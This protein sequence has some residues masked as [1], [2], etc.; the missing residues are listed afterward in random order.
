[1][2][3]YIGNCRICG[4]N[5]YCRDGFAEGVVTGQHELICFVCDK[6]QGDGGMNMDRRYPIGQYERPQTIDDEQLRKWTEELEGIPAEVK[7]SLEETADAVL[8]TPYRENG[9]TRRQ[10]AHHIADACMHS[11]IHFKLALT[12]DNPNI[13]PYEEDPWVKM[14]DESGSMLDVSM[15]LLE[16]IIARWTEMLRSMEASEFG[17]TFVHPVNGM[18]RLDDYLGFCV[19]HCRHHLAQIRLQESVGRNG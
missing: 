2:Q 4:K 16:S 13:K 15:N 19:W 5:L 7:K 6:I 18:R 3:E 14:A 17:R 11:Y 8:D 1:M 12:E 10:V 9:W